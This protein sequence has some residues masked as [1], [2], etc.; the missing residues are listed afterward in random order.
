MQEIIAVKSWAITLMQ[1]SLKREA[2]LFD[3]I[4]IPNLYALLSIANRKPSYFAK[5]LEWLI[6]K[7]IIFEPDVFSS[8]ERLKSNRQFHKYFDL[9]E[10]ASSKA[11]A[12]A[13]IRMMEKEKNKTRD[14]ENKDEE[15][16]DE[17]KLVLSTY[18]DYEARYAS[19]YLRERF[20]MP[21]YP[22]ILTWE[23][24]LRKTKA[25]K[26]DVIQVVLKHLPLPDD[27]TS[28][29]QIVDYR[30]DPDTA[31]KFLALKNWITEM[32]HTQLTP[33]EIEEKLEYLLYQ[34]QE[35]INLHKLKTNV[36]TLETIVTTSA[37]ILEN[38]IKLNWGKIAKN[39]FSLKQRRI[40]LIE[41]E[42]TAPGNQ[43]AFIVKS[44]KE[45][46]K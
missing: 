36:G 41:G 4:A 40:A 6:E 10:E 38:L 28:W 37:E 7:E 35:H 5:E 3:R 32:T 33:A 20:Q 29:E 9:A 13:L 24:Q 15:I 25:Q 19:I 22:I 39:L 26:S 21:A 1:Q 18:S 12:M 2:L 27:S 46:L 45:F 44:R 16:D 23:D 30:N 8:D 11:M 42:L 14:S 31:G 17:L 34:Y 43:V